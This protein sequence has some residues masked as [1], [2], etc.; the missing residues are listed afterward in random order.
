[1]AEHSAAVRIT[2]WIHTFAFLAL[3]LSGAAI[4]MAHPRLYWGEVGNFETPALIDLPI[5]LN[6]DQSGWGRSLHFLAAWVS[7]FYGL[8]YVLV[9]LSRRHFQ[10]NLVPSRKQLDWRTNVDR[11]SQYLRWKQPYDDDPDSY[12]GL[13]RLAYLSVVFILFPL[14]VWT[15]LAMSPAVTAAVPLLVDI[16]GGHQSARTIH[17]VV[18]NLLVLFL[19]IHIAMIMLSGFRH[20][21]RRMITGH[22]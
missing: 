21:V 14:M 11:V 3:L 20:R 6:L 12:N 19:I 4:L 18:T 15:G 7:A 9:G 17:F 16:L 13:Q 5:P 8:A 2:H 22:A 1:M 10:R